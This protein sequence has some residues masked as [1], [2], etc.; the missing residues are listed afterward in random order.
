M[1]RNI[2]ALAS[3]QLVTWMLTTVWVVFVPNRVGPRGM[4]EY[5]VGLAVANVL[6]VALGLGIGPLMIKEIARDH[7]RSGGLVG[8]ALFLRLAAVP[9]A[10]G[11][12]PVYLFLT[13]SGAELSTVIWLSVGAAAISMIANPL[14][15]A[16]QGLER[17]QYAAYSDVLRSLTTSQAVAATA[18]TAQYDSG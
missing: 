16:L 9:A 3:G 18:M 10:A 5:G 6:V 17:M 13:H 11:A 12:V 15:F 2:A 1:G 14:V 4:G 7:W 8:S